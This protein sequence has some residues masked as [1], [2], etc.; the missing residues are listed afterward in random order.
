[1]EKQLK[2]LSHFDDK[3]KGVA[4]NDILFYMRKGEKYAD[5]IIYIIQ[6]KIEIE[7][8]WGLTGSKEQWNKYFRTTDWNT[9]LNEFYEIMEY[10]EAW[11]NKSLVEKQRI[12]N[13]NKEYFIKQSMKGKEPTEKQISFLKSKGLTEIPNDRYEC[14]E[15]IDK[16]INQ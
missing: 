2:L 11:D 16:L 4:F 6:K 5:Q 8:R 10:A 1:M 12:K 9:Q 13:K 15:I 14:S 3:Y 7:K